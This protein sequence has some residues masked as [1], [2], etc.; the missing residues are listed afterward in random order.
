[1]AALAGFKF[2]DCDMRYENITTFSGISWRSDMGSRCEVSL[3]EEREELCWMCWHQVNVG[4]RTLVMAPNP[5]NGDG[6][7]ICGICGELGIDSMP[8][9]LRAL[10]H[11]SPMC[12]PS[13]RTVSSD[14]SLMTRKLIYSVTCHSSHSF[15]WI[16]F[17]WVVTAHVHNYWSHVAGGKKKVWVK[18]INNQL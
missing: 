4:V 16:C 12:Q 18:T 10:G 6:G 3:A 11:L 1:M 7:S 15:L 13:E 8:H 17:D 14:G 2:N 5:W 9:T